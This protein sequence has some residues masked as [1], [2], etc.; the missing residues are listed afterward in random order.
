[1]HAR[2]RGIDDTYEEFGNASKG[3]TTEEDDSLFDFGGKQR[4]KQQQQQGSQDRRNAKKKILPRVGDETSEDGGD[5]PS[6]SLALRTQEAWKR[7][8]AR[9]PKNNKNINTYTDESQQHVSFSATNPLIHRYNENA[10]EAS[11]LAGASLNS[12][13]TKSIE[14]EVE[15]A[16]KDIFLI[17]S[18]T[19]NNPG[20]RKLK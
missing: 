15:D 8:S 9:Q 20:R 7:K 6:A 18:G 10:T 4:P 19:G 13:Y 14:S 17:G 5:E 2:M 3:N 1:M 11:T 12:E 16:I